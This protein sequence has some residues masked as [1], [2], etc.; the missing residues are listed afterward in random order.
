MRIAEKFLSSGSLVEKPEHSTGRADSSGGIF[1]DFRVGLAA[2]G[3][4][5]PALIFTGH[6]EKSIASTVEDDRRKRQTIRRFRRH[7]NGRHP[8]LLFFERGRT[9]EK[10]CRVAFAPETKKLHIKCRRCR[11]KEFPQFRFIGIR[12]L[13]RLR[14]IRGNRM[15]VCGKDRNA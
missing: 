2:E 8:A 1:A 15:N 11:A 7:L 14:K 6:Q 9:G 10:R 12:G 3:G 4:K 5:N 13:L